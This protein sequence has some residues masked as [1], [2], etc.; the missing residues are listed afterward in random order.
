MDRKPI[1]IDP[2]EDDGQGTDRG[3]P[4]ASN[5]EEMAKIKSE[6]AL[7]KETLDTD[8]RTS[9]AS[10]TGVSLPLREL[11]PL[12]PPQLLATTSLGDDAD[13]QIEVPVGDLMDQL[14]S[15]RVAV[16]VSDL[17]MQFPVGLVAPANYPTRIHHRKTW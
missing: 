6:L 4:A 11:L 1:D 9:S 16:T 8:R 13:A 2:P 5:F 17:V 7:I 15:G 10:G 14:K 12:I 3:G